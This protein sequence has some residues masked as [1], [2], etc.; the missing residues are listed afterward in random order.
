VA[1]LV[2]FGGAAPA[3]GA[4]KPVVERDVP[5]GAPAPVSV[6]AAHGR[7]VTYHGGRVLHSSRGH[8]IFWQPSGSGLTFDPG[9]AALIDRFL[10]RVAAASHSTTNVYGLS[11][12]Y[13]DAAGPAAYASTYGGAVVATDRL[14]PNQCHE[15]STGPPGW[16]VCLTDAQL[17]SEIDHVVATDRLPHHA[18]DIYFLVLPNGFGTC[19][20]SSSNS[21]A[22]GGASNGYCGYHLVT[23]AGVL[24]AVVPYNAIAGHCQSTNPRPN[25]ST[26]DPAL[27]TL[28]HEQ[29]ELVTDPHGNAWSTASGDEIADLCLQRFGRNV[30]GAG[31]TAWNEVIDGGHYYLQ[32][33]WSNDDRGCAARAARDRVSFATPPRVRVGTPV[34]FTGRASDPHGSIVAYLWSFGRGAGASH[35]RRAKHVFVRPGVYRVVLRVSD[36]AGNWA[37]ATR[38][39]RVTR[40]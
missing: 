4:I 3:L 32:E 17:Q 40:R 8:V 7:R 6:R 13:R 21:C 31:G 38:V 30:G 18:T 23:G 1:L 16:N 20:D 36:S 35:R 9:Y 37:F 39:I 12:Q 28:D 14:P 24:Y 22:L 27:S 26:A 15:P 5:T 11:G 25:R 33:L 2:V 19:L 34:A 10:S 29:S